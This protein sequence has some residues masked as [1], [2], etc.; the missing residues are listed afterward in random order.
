MARRLFA[1]YRSRQ[2]D[3]SAVEQK[4]FRERRLA[5]VGVRDDRKGA[6]FLNFVSDI[7]QSKASLCEL[8]SV[9]SGPVLG[10]LP[11]PVFRPDSQFFIIQYFTLKFHTRDGFPEGLYC[12]TKKRESPSGAFPLLP[13]TG[14]SIFDRSKGRTRP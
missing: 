9:W 8:N 3:G 1:L 11:G 4:L 2:R 5:G 14:V 6:P 13:K 12:C 10:P 7:C